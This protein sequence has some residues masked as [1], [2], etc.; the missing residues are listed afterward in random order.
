VGS[1]VG[2][3]VSWCVGVFVCWRKGEEV[4]G[5]LVGVCGGKNEKGV[6]L[7]VGKYQL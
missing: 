2:G 4:G 3:F 7:V 6:L 1:C 5:V